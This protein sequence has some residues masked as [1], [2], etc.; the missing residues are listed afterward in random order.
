MSN[1]D[2][3]MGDKQSNVDHIWTTITFPEPFN[4][5]PVVLSQ[6]TS[7]NGNEAV[8]TRMRNIST[9]GF[10]VKLQEQQSGN[11]N[12][13]TEEVSWVAIEKGADNVNMIMEADATG[14]T[15][16][17]NWA[18]INFTNTYSNPVFIADLQTYAGSDPTGI[19][20]RNLNTTNVQVV[21]E[22]E[23]SSDNEMNHAYEDVGYVTFDAPG[24]ILDSLGTVIGEQ[25]TI[26]VTQANANS[27]TTIFFTTTYI[28]PVVVA[29]PVSYNE[30]DPT[31]IRIRNITANSF[32]NSN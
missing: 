6:V 1:G 2:K 25:G 4:N 12:V 26:N 10:E 30:N 13:A 19:R 17:H 7:A 27:W 29:G 23:R 31:T 16:R 22:E 24:D 9:T 5:V 18:N 15:V 32:P 20:Y 11:N 21:A 3:I 8:E 14:Y 28:N